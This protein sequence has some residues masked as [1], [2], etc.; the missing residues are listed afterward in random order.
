MQSVLFVCLGNIC[1][2]PMAETVFKK[3]VFESGKGR[4][5]EIDSAGLIDAHQGERADSRMRAHATRRDYD[6]THRSRPVRREDFDLFDLIVGMD[7]QNISGLKRL[8]RN[9][10]DLKKICRMTDF[11]EKFKGEAVPDPYYGGEAGFIHVIDM[12]EES[13]EGLLNYLSK[14]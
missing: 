1:R 12:L 9:E 3:K 6:I 2:S 13:C 11:S 8:A 7:D 14:D 5:F 10:S 4:E